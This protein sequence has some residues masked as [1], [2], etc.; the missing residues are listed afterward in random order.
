MNEVARR[1]G[2]P[3]QAAVQIGKGEAMSAV[4]VEETQFEARSIDE[5]GTGY[6]PRHSA[7]GT[8]KRR[9]KT[10]GLHRVVRRAD[11]RVVEEIWTWRNP[12]GPR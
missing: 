11:A 7:R 1:G 2:H 5:L 9:S 8:A 6:Q 4:M 3:G 10:A 12:D